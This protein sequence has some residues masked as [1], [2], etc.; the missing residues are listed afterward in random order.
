ME[1]ESEENPE[2][3]SGEH[4]IPKSEDRVQE[5]ARGRREPDKKSTLPGQLH[6]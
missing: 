6:V 4:S 3:L 5:R 1:P 2:P